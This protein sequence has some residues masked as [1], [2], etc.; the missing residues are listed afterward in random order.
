MNTILHLGSPAL[1]LLRVY[2]VSPEK[3][4]TYYNIYASS[5]SSYGYAYYRR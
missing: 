3:S 4:I 5:S 1:P 2:Q